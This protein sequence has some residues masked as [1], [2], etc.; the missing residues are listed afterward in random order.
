MI[1][2]HVSILYYGMTISAILQ[3][4]LKATQDILTKC[5]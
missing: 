4:C 2:F 5:S 3:G 1:P